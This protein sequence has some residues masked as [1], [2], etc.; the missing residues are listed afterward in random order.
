LGYLEAATLLE[1]TIMKLITHFVME[2]ETPGTYRFAEAD[3]AF[4]R[5]GK[6][7]EKVVG[8]L[9]V[10]KTAFDGRAATNTL[11]VTIEG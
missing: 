3:A 10:K 5:K 2:K 11:T 7:D 8:T 9:Y 4:V 1:E 6:D